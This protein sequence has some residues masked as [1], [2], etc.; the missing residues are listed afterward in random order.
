MVL[1]L[2]IGRPWDE[3]LAGATFILEWIAKITTPAG[4]IDITGVST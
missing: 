3:N 2:L 4:C 1:V